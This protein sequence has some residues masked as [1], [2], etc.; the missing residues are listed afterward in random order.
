MHCFPGRQPLRE[1]QEG[2]AEIC[3]L[4]ADSSKSSFLLEQ[5]PESELLGVL[6]V[7][8]TAKRKALKPLRVIKGL[9]SKA[10]AELILLDLI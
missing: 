9:L 4:K 10:S 1:S 2:E 7:S 5:H 8:S 6:P 3:C